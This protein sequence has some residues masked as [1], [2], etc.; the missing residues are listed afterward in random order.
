LTQLNLILPGYYDAT[1]TNTAISDYAHTKL[2]WQK[3][4]T[5]LVQYCLRSETADTGTN[6]IVS[7]SA[8][9]NEVV[10]G[11]LTIAA[12][13]TLY[14]T[15]LVDPTYYAINRGDLIDAIIT[16]GANADGAYL[17]MY[18]LFVTY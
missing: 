17:T 3:S 6:G 8:Q 10:S 14:C 11:G 16:P 4:L 13:D 2:F 7:I 1:A 12:N 5:Q 15:T 18:L 9:N